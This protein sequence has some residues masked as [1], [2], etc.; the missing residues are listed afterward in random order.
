MLQSDSFERAVT[1]YRTR[2]KKM[3]TTRTQ[4]L[5]LSEPQPQSEVQSLTQIQ[6]QPLTPSSPNV[7]FQPHVPS[8][9]SLRPRQTFSLEQDD[10]GGEGSRQP[11]DTEVKAPGPTL[12]AQD[13]LETLP[14]HVL[15]EARSFQEYMR[16]LENSGS[17]TN[18]YV[19]EGLKTL[20]DDV[21]GVDDM[22]ESV[23]I[24]ILRDRDVRRVS[25]PSL[26]I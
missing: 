9:S 6:T 15:N 7:R 16:Y 25:R 13:L 14:R 3:Y 17:G 19:N 23:K 22:K 24:D 1:M 4:S 2:T 10:S 8:S 20:L 21:V 18:A 11:Q 5:S 26:T 12:R